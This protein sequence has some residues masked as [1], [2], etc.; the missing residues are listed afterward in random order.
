MASSQPLIREDSH[1][2]FRSVAGTVG[3][4]AAILGMLCRDPADLAAAHARLVVVADR[5]DALVCELFGVPDAAGRCALGRALHSVVVHLRTAAERASGHRA[6]TLVD[7]LTE[8]IGIVEECGQHT[9]RSLTAPL[10]SIEA[11][12]YRAEIRR[13]ADDADDAFRR[14]FARWYFDT[15]DLM[16]V[17]EMRDLGDEL[18]NV[19]QAFESVADAMLV[20]DR[21]P[22]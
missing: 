11:Q 5:S 7:E 2:C 8:V 14:L 20:T 12:R 19:V 17:A 9:A 13:L 10:N 21:R 18:E 22:G 15:D 16:A 6:T 3:Q 1:D 4:A